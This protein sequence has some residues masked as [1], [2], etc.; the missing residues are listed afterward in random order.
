MMG[1]KH[2][3]AEPGLKKAHPTSAVA[4]PAHWNAEQPDHEKIRDWE[5]LRD[6][7]AAGVERP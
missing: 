3:F 5:F 4:A 7:S 1:R 2:G 6:D